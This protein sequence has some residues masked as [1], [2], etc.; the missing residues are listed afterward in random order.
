[1]L[2]RSIRRGLPLLYLESESS[3]IEEI[4]A[5]LCGLTPFCESESSII[6]EIA[7]ALCRLTPFCESESSFIEEIAAA[8]FGLTPFC[9]A[10]VVKHSHTSTLL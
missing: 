3:I 2:L 7:A 4:A 8:L 6:E 10:P 5:A 1:M 9:E